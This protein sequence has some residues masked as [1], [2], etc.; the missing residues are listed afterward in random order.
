[1]KDEKNKKKQEL[2]INIFFND[3]GENIIEIL[4]SDFE[5]FANKFLKLAVL[6]NN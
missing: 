6:K 4:E 2:D 1:M 3:N 5:N